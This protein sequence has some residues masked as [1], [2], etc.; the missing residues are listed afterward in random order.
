MCIVF[1]LS[2][3]LIV[4]KLVSIFLFHI[5]SAKSQQ[6]APV[7]VSETICVCLHNGIYLPCI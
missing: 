4:I 6:G 7:E 1:M 3:A 5:E 2:Y